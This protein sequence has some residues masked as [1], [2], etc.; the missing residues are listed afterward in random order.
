MTLDNSD[1]AGVSPWLARRGLSLRGGGELLLNGHSLSEAASRFGTPLYLYSAPVLAESW[2]DF[3]ET[4]RRA[5]VAAGAEV[6]VCYSLKANPHLALVSLL[7][8]AGAGAD[9]VSGGELARALRAGVA[10]ERM[11]FAG[12]AKSD[13]E[14]RAGLKAGIL[15]FNAE[16]AGELRALQGLARATDAR[17][18]VSLRFNPNVAGGGHDK[19]STGRAGDK[20]GLARDEILSLAAGWEHFDRL[21]LRGLSVH[22]GSQMDT[23]APMTRAWDAMLEVFTALAAT[24]HERLDRAD[25]GGGVGVDYGGGDGGD[26]DGGLSLAEYGSALEDFARRFCDFAGG[27][28]GAP[29]V[30]L[31]PGRRIAAG[32]GLLLSRVVRVKRGGVVL[33]DAG[34]NDFLRPALYGARHRIVPVVS[35]GA[36]GAGDINKDGV[37][38][39]GPVCESSDIFARGIGGA[40]GLAL[41]GLSEG[42]LVLICDVGA[43]GSVMASNY[44]SRGRACE[45]LVSGGG[46]EVIT[47]RE[48]LD[49]ML[50][51]ERI[52]TN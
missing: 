28:V 30:I 42:D 5:C 49:D 2:R 10:P 13:D 27:G 48:T 52:L 17:A 47:P 29:L 39:A 44:N 40:E 19:I 4:A 43:Y 37:T 33:V 50:S 46:L 45:V 35:A 16:S 34:M 22:V 51:R 3:S 15:Q 9:L 1:S 26:G 23:T 25:L 24:G 7:A 11:V 12:V 36:G 6:L 18:S 31:E 14:L 32:C 8:R 20:F 21:D 41:S 38:V